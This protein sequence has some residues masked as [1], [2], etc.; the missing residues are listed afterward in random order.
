MEYWVI[1]G[2]GDT[3]KA[4]MRI[5]MAL[6]SCCFQELVGYRCF[7]LNFL[8]LFQELKPGFVLFFNLKPG[9]VLFFI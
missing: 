9:F 4:T 3:P 2:L 1:E 7:F 5:V 6:D 8:I